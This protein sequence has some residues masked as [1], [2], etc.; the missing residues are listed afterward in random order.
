[1]RLPDKIRL[2]ILRRH[3]VK[4]IKGMDRYD[5]V[6]SCI[7]AQALKER[8]PSRRFNVGVSLVF[9]PGKI[10]VCYD[11]DRNGCRLIERATYGKKVKPTT[12][13]LRSRYA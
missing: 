8:F 7:V 3:I 9:L 12:I 5:P 13:T 2:K 6:T 4:G 10:R 1:M 11:I